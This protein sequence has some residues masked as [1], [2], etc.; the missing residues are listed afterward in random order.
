[1]NMG[2]TNGAP[3]SIYSFLV[4]LNSDTYI[5]GSNQTPYLSIVSLNND[6][7][8]HLDEYYPLLL[9]KT[10]LYIIGM[11]NPNKENII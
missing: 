6:T 9:L 11:L 2:G 7:P 1:M 8:M 3:I 4:F 10:G 5:V